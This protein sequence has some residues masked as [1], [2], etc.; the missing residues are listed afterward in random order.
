MS[1]NKRI[2]VRPDQLKILKLENRR[3]KPMAETLI[4]PKQHRSAKVAA[5]A[6]VA[7]AISTQLDA[8]HAFAAKLGVSAASAEQSVAA[9]EQACDR[10]D[11]LIA[12]V[13]S[14]NS[15]STLKAPLVELFSIVQAEHE[16]MEELAKEAGARLVEHFGPSAA[17]D[18]SKRPPTA[19]LNQLLTQAFSS[20]AS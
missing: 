6:A 20:L 11:D 4:D 12:L 15:A 19:W 17:G 13:E 14:G 16:K 18:G 10:C 7:L 9:F 1:A 8:P 3:L 5:I 2:D